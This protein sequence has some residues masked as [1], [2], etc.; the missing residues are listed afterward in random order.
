MN[1]YGF[2]FTDKE[3]ADVL[4]GD[5]PSVYK[6]LADDPNHRSMYQALAD[7]PECIKHV[8]ERIL[9]FAIECFAEDV[10]EAANDYAYNVK[11]D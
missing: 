8:A 2:A 4:R 1:F 7:D 10:F 9:G 6:A 11:E 3:I 5:H